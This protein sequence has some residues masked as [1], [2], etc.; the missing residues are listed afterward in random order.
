M[1]EGQA[2]IVPASYS[3][4]LPIICCSVNYAFVR[5][6]GLKYPCADAA[7]W[8]FSIGSGLNFRFLRPPERHRETW[9]N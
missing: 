7:D 5:H 2:S 4:K 9:H 8:G 1:C 6:L 3:P